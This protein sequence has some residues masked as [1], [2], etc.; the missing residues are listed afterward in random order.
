MFWDPPH[1]RGD[2]TVMT[3]GVAL[4]QYTGPKCRL[5]ELGLGSQRAGLLC[6]GL[7]GAK[8]KPQQC[9]KTVILMP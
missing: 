7:F 3:W 4:L 6:A 8:A 9:T 1:R 2:G 5:Q